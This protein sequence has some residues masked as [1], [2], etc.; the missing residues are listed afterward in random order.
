MPE[1]VFVTGGSGFVGSAV[2]DELVARGYAVHALSSSKP[3]DPRGGKVR[4][5]AGGLFDAA[6]L[7]AGISGCAAVIH[8]VGVIMER[9]AKGAT[10]E[11]IHVGGTKA[12][13]D[14][15]KRAGVRR[16]VHMSALGT[17][18]DAV[19]EYHRTKWEAEEYVRSCGLDW[20][21]LR[22]SMIHGPKGEFMQM[23]A[24]WARK[25]KLPYLFMPYF[26]SGVL[27][28]GKGGK[29]QPVYVGDVARA[30]VD[31]VDKQNTIGKTYDLGGPEQTDWPTMHKMISGVLTGKPRLTLPIPAWYAKALTRVLPAS[32]LPFNRAQVVMSQEDN[33]GDGRKFRDD[34]GWYPKRFE[35]TLRAYKDEL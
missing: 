3:I 7:E 16:Y 6:A 14:A 28:L 23:E 24:A 25:R 10:F 32:L 12:V 31:A 8:L 2:I 22:P 15:A 13:V 17:R 21:M 19:S 9:P 29:I 11:R 5:F 30:F 4:S 26:G 27:G 35:E 33:V 1:P 18:P 20:T 34:F